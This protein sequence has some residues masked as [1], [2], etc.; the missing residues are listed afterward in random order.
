MKQK[1]FFLLVSLIS[2]AAYSPAQTVGETRAFADSL[3]TAGHLN[4]ALPAYQRTAFFIRPTVDAEVL[5]RIADCFYSGGDLE[6][7][8]EFY[9]HSY[10]AQTNDSI[11]KEVLFR[12]SACYL[13]SHNYNFALMELLSLEDSLSPG[14]EKKRNFYLGMT[15]FGLEDFSKAGSYFEKAAE[16]SMSQQKIKAIFADI[17]HFYLPNPKLASWLSIIL[18]GA[19]QIYS[20][21]IWSGINSLLLT[22]FFVGLGFYIV[23]V[24]SPVDALFTALPWFQ[25]YYQGGFQH[26]A[27]FAKN[28]RTENRSK[29]FNEVLAVIASTK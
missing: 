13:R 16:D 20:G 22:G 6:K 12:K 29:I 10:F 27:D 24:S 1:V 11:K 5:N 26:A 21:E 3:Y 4:E 7:A 17:R 15:W 18:P 8:L 28:K 14:L 9:D 23:S 25:R 2:L 19:G